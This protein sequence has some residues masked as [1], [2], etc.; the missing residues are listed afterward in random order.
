MSR[1]TV[2]RQR[3]DEAL[4]DRFRQ[5]LKKNPKWRIDAVIEMVAGEFYLSSVT[6]TKILKG[7]NVSHIPDP[8]TISRRLNQQNVCNN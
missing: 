5:H 4:K 8:S 3:R 1:N 7:Q 6:V 2:L